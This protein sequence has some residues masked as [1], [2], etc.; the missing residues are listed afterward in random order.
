MIILTDGE[1]EDVEKEWVKGWKKVV[2]I[3]QSKEALKNVESERNV[4]IAYYEA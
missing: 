3:T 4:E 1:T 2:F